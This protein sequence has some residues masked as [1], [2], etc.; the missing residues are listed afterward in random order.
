[1]RPGLTAHS[2]VRDAE[3]NA[4]HCLHFEGNDLNLQPPGGVDS[5]CQA[6]LKTVAR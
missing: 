4:F 1:M 5:G 3:G 6:V 2:K